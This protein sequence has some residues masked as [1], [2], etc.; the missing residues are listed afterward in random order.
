MRSDTFWHKFPT[1]P[2]RDGIIG[3]IELHPQIS[4]CFYG[5]YKCTLNCELIILGSLFD[6]HN[7]SRTETETYRRVF[8]RNNDLSLEH[9]HMSR[10]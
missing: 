5:R 9:V 1:S 8:P 6:T 2:Q 3:F 4:E 7:E 10:Q